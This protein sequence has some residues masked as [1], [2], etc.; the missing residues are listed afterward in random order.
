MSQ[1]KTIVPGFEFE[2]MGAS[3][4]ESSIFD[5][6]Y[7]RSHVDSNATFIPDV[8]QAIPSMN[9]P[10]QAPSVQASS[11]VEG[12]CSRTIC[13]EERVVAGVLFS[14]SKGIL[15]EIFPLYLGDNLIGNTEDCDVRLFEKSISPK[16]LLLN[17]KK[18]GDPIQYKVTITD[19]N[20]MFGTMVNETDARYESLSI[21]ENDI[22]TVG[23]HYKFIIKLFEV[24]KAN[25]LEEEGFESLQEDL[26]KPLEQPLN[27]QS[28]LSNSFYTPTNKKSDSTKTVLY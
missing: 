15:G 16:H 18:I 10:S 20:S 3:E 11:Q 13:L 2:S 8:N 25:L 17:I 26:A 28:N 21:S 12:C 27:E 9:S 19:L 6:L 22:L 5:E 7:G 1:N 23:L 24:E 14:I 4:S